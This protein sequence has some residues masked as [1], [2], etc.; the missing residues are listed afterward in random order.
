M[1]A[2]QWIANFWY[3]QNYH[4]AQSGALGTRSGYRWTVRNNTIRY[5]KT[6]GFDWG[7][8]GGYAGHPTDNEGTNQS[9]P[10]VHGDHT[11]E[12]NVFE[13]NEVSGVQ[14]YGATGNFRYNL[15]QDNGGL[16]CAG[17]ENAAFKS[18]GFNGTFEGNVFRRN[19]VGLPIWFDGQGGAVHFTRNVILVDVRHDAEAVFFELGAGP[20]VADNNIFVGPGWGSSA[21]VV[22]QDHSGANL[23]HNLVAK[24]NGAAVDLHGLTGRSNSPMKDWWL[25]GNMLLSSGKGPWLHMHNRK[26][27][28]G[29]DAIQNETAQHNL[30]TGGNP[31]VPPNQPGDLNITVDPV[32]KRA[33]SL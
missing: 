25:G 19:T 33:F 23:G 32:R 4:Y 21:G 8:E 5:A 18:H 28:A 29:N 20:V 7:T 26:E 17:A 30:V 2:N 22:A 3:P 6:I 11:V 9:I 13:R 16:G 10:A 1:Q 14:G 15:L 24:F 31:V 12:N 27:F